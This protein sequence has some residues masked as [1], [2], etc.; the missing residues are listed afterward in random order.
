MSDIYLEFQNKVYTEE[1]F[2]SLTE[3]YKTNDDCTDIANMPYDTDY[4]L[5]VLSAVENNKPL[6]SGG[7]GLSAAAINKWLEFNCFIFY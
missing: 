1:K 3:S 6:V 2:K 5:S 7:I 4:I